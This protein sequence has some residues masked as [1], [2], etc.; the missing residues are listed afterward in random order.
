MKRR[1]NSYNNLEKIFFWTF[2]KLLSVSE[3]VMYIKSLN[4]FKL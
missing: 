4:S 3:H 1:I 2:V